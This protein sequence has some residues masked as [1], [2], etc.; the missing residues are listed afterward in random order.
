[1]IFIAYNKPNR[2]GGG[3]FVSQK[4]SNR[5]KKVRLGNS[6]RRRAFSSID[7]LDQ[8]AYNYAG[9]CGHHT[10][11]LQV[12]FCGGFVFMKVVVVKSPKILA[13]ILRMFFK[14]KKTEI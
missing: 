5:Q 1:M 3:Y 10:W 2:K 12:T 6:F 14:I 13:G 9:C 8:V 4:N 7:L 11:M